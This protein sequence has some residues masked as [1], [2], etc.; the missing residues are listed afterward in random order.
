M[1]G[2]KVDDFL[3]DESAVHVEYYQSRVAP[4]YGI[5]LEDHIHVPLLLES[6][7]HLVLPQ[8]VQTEVIGRWCRRERQ[9]N[10]ARL[11]LVVQTSVRRVRLIGILGKRER[12]HEMEE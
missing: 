6:V 11:L 3:S 9:L 4:P 12:R 8:V 7:D 1:I 10:N 5:P 2:Q